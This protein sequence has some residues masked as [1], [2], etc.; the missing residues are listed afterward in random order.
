M[1]ILKKLIVAIALMGFL[2]QMT[3]VYAMDLEEYDEGDD[4]LYEEQKRLSHKKLLYASMAGDAQVV[5]EA[6]SEGANVNLHTKDG[7]TPLQWAAT[8]GYASV[9][10]IL[11]D[12]KARVDT[13]DQ[14]GATPL[15]MA[16]YRGHLPIVQ[17]LLD[18][19]NA[20]P[21][22]GK[23]IGGIV[24]SPLSCAADKGNREIVKMLLVAGAQ[25]SGQESEQAKMVISAA[26]AELCNHAIVENMLHSMLH[27]M[28]F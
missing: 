5:A 12:G 28:S 11:L 1:Q 9:V 16:V 23:G 19:G 6:I 8:R 17:I 26:R 3:N 13:A 20:D 21:N 2:G 25:P 10:S 22:R 18:N 15:C 24:T 27:G 7:E 4:Q 14:W